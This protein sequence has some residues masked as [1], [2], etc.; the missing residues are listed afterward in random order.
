[1][2][3]TIAWETRDGRPAATDARGADLGETC[4]WLRENRDAIYAARAMYE[5]ALS[6]EPEDG[7]VKFSLLPKVAKSAR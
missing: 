3:T 2:N 5:K 1:M 7:W 6:M 4:E